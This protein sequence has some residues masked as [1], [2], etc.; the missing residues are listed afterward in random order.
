ME[1]LNFAN[2]KWVFMLKSVEKWLRVEWIRGFKIQFQSFWSHHAIVLRSPQIFCG[3]RFF[4][5]SDFFMVSDFFV[6]TDFFW[7][8]KF[9]LID[10]AH[11]SIF[12]TN[13]ESF[14]NHHRLFFI[15]T[16]GRDRDRDTDIPKS[17][18]N[19]FGV[20]TPFSIVL[21]S[22]QIFCGVRFFCGVWFFC[23]DRFF[24]K[25]KIFIDR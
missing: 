23:D 12:A 17:I 10:N 14:S 8:R 25:Q 3:V 5:V 20:T 2:I 11:E 16:K 18:F 13:T 19:R 1:V 21:R 9:L 7:S 24:L 22:P 15:V 4:V 6:M